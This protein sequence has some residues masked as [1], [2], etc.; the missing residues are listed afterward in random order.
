[1]LAGGLTNAQVAGALFISP[2]T[3]SAHAEHIYRK[4]GVSTRAAATAFALGHDLVQ[5][6]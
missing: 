4:I 5:I 3:V 6:G 1:M 2:K